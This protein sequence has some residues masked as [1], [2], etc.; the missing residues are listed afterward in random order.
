MAGTTATAATAAHGETVG[1][2]TPA[3]EATS[4]P[5]TNQREATDASWGHA[6][7][8]WRQQLFALAGKIKSDLAMLL[9]AVFRL[10]CRP[11]I[12]R[13][14]YALDKFTPPMHS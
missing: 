11:V 8:N 6:F 4:G 7:E 3:G 9:L 12:S 13:T 14:A 2:G 5:V 1:G 10:S